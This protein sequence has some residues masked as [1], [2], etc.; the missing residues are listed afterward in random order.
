MHVGYGKSADCFLLGRD[1]SEDCVEDSCHDELKAGGR[2]S[3]HPT[4]HSN[5][6]LA[7]LF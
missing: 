5:P 3:G 6:Y 4:S 7:S 1:S 2:K